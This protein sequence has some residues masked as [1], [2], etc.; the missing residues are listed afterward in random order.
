MMTEAPSPADLSIDRLDVIAPGAFA[1]AVA[2]LFEGARLFLGR[3]AMARP[4]GSVEELFARAREIAHTMP[5]T[6]RSS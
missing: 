1:A 4:F 2:P 3:L 6:R 5:S